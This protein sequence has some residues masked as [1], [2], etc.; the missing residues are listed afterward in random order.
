MEK[1]NLP[2]PLGKVFSKSFS[3][4]FQFD[5]L[6]P[7]FIR[8]RSN[9]HWTPLTVARQAARFLAVDDNVNILDIG[10]GA[11]KFCLAAAYYRPGAVYYGIEQRQS[12][13]YYAEKVRQTLEMENVHF[14]HGNITQIDLRNYD[15][16]YFYN[17]FYENLPGTDKIDESIDYSPSL[18][19][20]YNRYLYAQFAL[21]PYGTRLATFHSLEYEIPPC[22]QVVETDYDELLK[23]WIK[24]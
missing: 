6:Y 9:C 24:V 12:L 1:A 10:S 20:Y 7:E 19:D 21:L 18:Y 16:F 11:G 14:K 5:Q 15:H 22:Y 8:K 17:S 3:A 4:D 13:H 23:C 2:Q